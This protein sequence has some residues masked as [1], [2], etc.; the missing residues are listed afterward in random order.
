M[1]TPPASTM[2]RTLPGPTCDD[3]FMCPQVLGKGGDGGSRKLSATARLAGVWRL[4]SGL[5]GRHNKAAFHPWLM[6]QEHPSIDQF[7]HIRIVTLMGHEIHGS[8][9][10]RG[11]SGD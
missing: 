3:Q 11:F 5:M 2:K 7:Q 9:S 4:L 1:H 8:Q 10:P 6:G